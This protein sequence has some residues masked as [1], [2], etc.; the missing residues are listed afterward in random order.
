MRAYWVLPTVV[1]FL[2]GCARGLPGAGPVPARSAAP[3]AIVVPAPPR[4]TVWAPATAQAPQPAAAKDPAPVAPA[5]DADAEAGVVRVNDAHLHLLNYAQHGTTIDDFLKMVGDRV[6]RVALFGIPVQQKWD[7]F[8]SGDRAPDYYLHSD[9]PLYY[10]S[11]VD[12]MIAHEYLS[13]TQEQ[14]R[15]VDPLLCGFNPT[16]MYA[17]EHIERVLLMYP[18]V[19]SGIGEFSV[20]KE[21]VSSK[22]TGHTASLRN[23]ALD[24][25]FDKAEEI[26]LVVLLHCDVDAMRSTSPRTAHFDDL[27]KVFSAHPG[28]TIIWAHTGLGRYRTSSSRDR[29]PRSATGRAGPR[30]PVGEIPRAVPAGFATRFPAPARTPTQ[31]GVPS[32][33]PARRR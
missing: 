19:F 12:A 27:V 26:G 32:R 4:T 6:E 20:H 16:D 15:R 14:K 3:V 13:L 2:A 9:A 28:T 33:R 8:V 18:G 31:G 5:A 1:L 24:A 17:P 10:Y 11:F 7:Y 25:V 22:V 21:F 30:A 29:R 23:E